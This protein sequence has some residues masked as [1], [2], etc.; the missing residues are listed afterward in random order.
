MADRIIGIDV[1]GTYT[2]L[3]VLDTASLAVSILKVPSTRGDEA[4]GFLN[5]VLRASPQVPDIASI[6]HGTTVATNALLERKVARC[7]L[8]TT[9]G[10]RDVLEMRRRDRPQT[11]GLTGN[12]T[13]LIARDLRLEVD[14]RVLADGTV[15]T[16]VNLDQV[17][18]AAQQLLAAG[19]QSV[20]IFF[21]NSFAQFGNEKAA[22]AE[23][24]KL[25]LNHHVTASHE[26]LPEI[27]E[28]ERCSTAV[29][30][31]CLQP[32]VG[33]YL[34][35]LSREL[36]RRDFA[37]DLLIVQ[38]SGGVMSAA[39]ASELPVR[40]ALSGPAAGVIAC[41]HIAQASGF[42]NVITGDVGGTSFDVS[43]ILDGQAAL[44]AQTSIDYGMVVR[45]P[46]IQIETIGAGGGSIAVI[47]GGGLLRV[48]P[49]SAGSNPGPACYGRGGKRATLT[50]ANVLLGRIDASRPIGGGALSVLRAQAAIEEQ[51]AKPLGLDV[52]Q[53]AEAILTVA[54]A[55]MAGAIRLVS[56][57][58]GH[59]PRK[60]AYMP[61]GG[62]G[63]LH[64]CAML[65]EVGVDAAI[66]PRYPGV[67]SALGCVLA[68]LRHDRVQTLS[69][70]LDALDPAGLLQHIEVMSG[71]CQQRLDAARA[72]FERRIE[73]IELDMLYVGQTHT[74]AVAVGR[75]QLSQEALRKAFERAYQQAFSR[76]LQGMAIRII[77]LRYALVGVRP[78]FD[79]R[80]LAPTSRAVV[81]AQPAEPSDPNAT[82]PHST[83]PHASQL[84]LT[85]LRR[86]YH[87]GHWH[88]ANVYARL[89]LA[90]ASELSGPAIL[91][92]AD[93][94]IW[95]EPG[96]SA[97]V[98]ELGNLIIRNTRR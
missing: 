70:M 45:A 63:A 37:G 60:F 62:G 18:A 6:V 68:D 5:G 94:T 57:E 14:E 53:A 49:E 85:G 82:P 13:P 32:V 9:R 4:N 64:A 87:A 39:T 1:G 90:V 2:D 16:A 83:Q 54:N 33:E 88:E 75:D 38:S 80:I 44:A 47:D 12:F 46:M 97:R 7:G 20:C 69:I 92:Q 76:T 66:I 72:R 31:A 55:R 24:R 91:E 65:R 22:A 98:D 58:R 67:T 78:K 41:A 19:C 34:N 26:V 10:F 71:Q 52:W 77:N 8:I 17:R 29:L 50:D 28:F 96:F 56:I 81:H 43:L 95:L 73:S 42:A 21:I 15:H 23:V 30:N 40:T 74:L 59:D 93:T 3:F 61:F 11:W 35:R 25:W 48:G 51:I 86:V 36:E 84:S 27:R 89:E 79:L